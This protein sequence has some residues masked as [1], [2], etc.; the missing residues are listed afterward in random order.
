[1]IEAAWRPSSG[2]VASRTIVVEI[3]LLVIRFGRR[4]EVTR[5]AVETS[6]R[7]IRV[8]RTMARDTRGGSMSAG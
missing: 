1:M 2:R 4:G 3:V 6:V 8:A 5:V 7:R